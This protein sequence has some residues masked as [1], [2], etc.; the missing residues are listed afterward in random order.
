MTFPDKSALPNLT[1]NK[2]Q[3][4]IMATTPD[5]P[6]LKVNSLVI[7]Q[8]LDSPTSSGMNCLGAF[9]MLSPLPGI[10]SHGHLLP[11]FNQILVDLWASLVDQ[12][13]KNLPA[14][15]ETWVRSLGWGDLLEKEQLPTVVFW[16]GEFHGQRSLEGYSPWGLK[17]S[18]TTIFI[19]FFLWISLAQHL[20][21]PCP[22]LD[23]V[24]SL[25]LLL[26]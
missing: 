9:V 17:Q 2:S 24:P 14:M 26:Y 20:L 6:F 4:L 1:E 3:G 23:R 16:P 21:L 11:Q 15:L 5:L 7:P 10:L 25:S 19:S 18:N 22:R 13:V 8:G 12:T